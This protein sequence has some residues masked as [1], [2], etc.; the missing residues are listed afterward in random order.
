MATQGLLLQLTLFWVVLAVA[1]AEQA[2]PIAKRGCQDKCGNVSIPH[3]FGTTDKCYYDPE[4]L[5]T[6]NDTFD[7]PKAFMT[8]SNI[9]VTNITLGGK[10]HIWQYIASDCY[11]KSGEPI[12]DNKPWLRLSKFIISDTDNKFTAVGCDTEAYVNGSQGEKTFK[13]GCLSVCDSIDYV[14]NGSCSGV[15][16]CQTSI[17]KG[18]DYVK[19][20]V[21]S[22]NNHTRVWDF[23]PCSYAFIVEASQFNF[24]STYLKDLRNVTFLP[25]VLDWSIGN[26]TCQ[27][28][29]RD[30]RRYACQGNS[31]CV[32][33]ENGSGYRCKCLEGYQG[34]PYLPNG[35]QDIDECQDSSL[36]NCERICINREGSYTCL[37]PKGH[38]GDGRKDGEGCSADRSLVIQLT[39]G[40]SVCL[41]GLLMGGTWLYCGFN[42]WKLIKLREKFFRQNGGFLLQQQL[43]G[44][45]GSTRE[46]AKIF[47]TEEL[48]KA[49][50]NYSESRILGR[51]G[52][53]TVY[54]GILSNGKIAAIKRSK[55]VDQSQIEQFINEVIVL[56]QINHRNVVKLLG[57]CL[58]TEV[59][60]LV[61]EY[62]TNGTLFDH[63]HTKSKV[64][65]LPWETRLRIAAETAGV[66]SYLHSSAS[67]PIIHRDIKSTNILLDDHY[68]AK[69]ADFGASSLVPL[70][71]EGL[72]TIVQGT[73]GY[74]DPEY[75]HTSQLTEKSDVYSFGVVLIE[76]LTGKKAISFDGPEEE[77]NLGMY[78][79]SALKEHRLTEVVDDGVSK[80]ANPEQLKEIASLARRC[81][82]VK[83]EERPTMKEV[84]MELEG[85]RIM[86]KHPWVNDKSNL[87]ETDYL[88]GESSESDAVSFG[89]SSSMSGGYGS[90]RNHVIENVRDGR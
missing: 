25:L 39:V 2:H 12:A 34:N 53:G 11:K 70:D 10:L 28:V 72:C 61:Y 87:E 54:K 80:E 59:P 49:T 23:N 88:L 76:L 86:V 47:T 27:Q 13:V 24:S 71:Q 21:R 6:C 45:E 50:D 38:H 74:L 67:T 42:K 44:R 51:G 16:C 73:I 20:T 58:E 55:V 29:K 32:D 30:M 3:P 9:E 90:M 15:G 77:R 41:T 84:A 14:S 68:T 7:P 79:V 56:S 81:V 62:I 60:L 35:C 8:D 5:V 57:C 33:S 64:S 75:L 36:H 19:L 22:Y 65:V 31:D 82:R 63:I 1:A 43:S 40:I 69:V 83:G 52:Y 78:F 85:L 37:C 18:M 26:K 89:V 48:E 4:F 46:T 17:P 66:L